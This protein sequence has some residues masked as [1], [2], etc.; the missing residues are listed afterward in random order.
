V[1]VRCQGFYHYSVL[2]GCPV[3]RVVVYDWK[4]NEEFLKEDNV[5][6]YDCRTK[7]ITMRCINF[8]QGSDELFRKK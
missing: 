8:L 7:N 6:Q 4:A 2:N 1:R 5:V 3:S